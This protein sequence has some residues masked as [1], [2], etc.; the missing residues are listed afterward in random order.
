MTKITFRDALAS[1]HRALGQPASGAVA[2]RHRTLVRLAIGALALG[3]SLALWPAAA[4]AG[5]LHPSFPLLDE[6]GVSVL[7]S[8]NAVSPARTC[9]TCHDTNYI[10]SQDSHATS[11]AALD[12][13]LC[14]LAGADDDARKDAIASGNQRWAATAT[15]SSTGIV[16]A[17]DGT[18]AYSPEAFDAQGNVRRSFLSVQ[19]PTSDACGSCH[20]TVE[21]DLETP[22]LWP[23]VDPVTAPKWSS[24]QTGQVFSPQPMN[25]SGLN[26][27]EKG[28]LTRTWDVHAERRLDCVDCHYST[29]NP[30]YRRVSSVRPDHLRFDARRI[31]LGEYLR[32]PSHILAH[33]VEVEAGD[34]EGT[35]RDCG[36]C[37]DSSVGHDWLP[38]AERHFTHL[39][40][41]ACH[42]PD[43]HAPALAA[44]DAT[45]ARA[46]GAPRIHLRG[47]EGPAADQWGYDLSASI[48]STYVSG[49]QPTLL[50]RVEADGTTRLAPHNLVTTYRWIDTNGAEV[51][52]TTVAAALYDGAGRPKPSI[53]ALFDADGNGTWSDTELRISTDAQK[54]GVANALAATGVAG[55]KLD[56]LTVPYSITHGVT[57]GR[58]A[59]RDCKQ[60]HEE[61]SR[62][63][64]AVVL[65]TSGL[66]GIDP[67]FGGDART[68]LAGTIRNDADGQ[69]RFSPEPRPET[70]VLGKHA[71]VVVNRIGLLSVLGVILGIG[72]HALARVIK[73]RMSSTNG[74]AAHGHESHGGHAGSAGGAAKSVYMYSAYERFWHWLQAAAI[75]FLLVTGLEIH[76]PG[77][78]RILGFELAVR[79][80]NIIAFVVVLNAALAAFFHFA[81][82]EIRQFLPEPQGFFR[83]AILQI[84]YYLF[85]I[86]RGEPHPFEK[87]PNQ[88]MNALQQVTYLAILN[89]LLPLQI[90]TGL[91][92]WGAQ[93][94]STVDSVFG[95]LGVLGPIH[96]LGAWLFAAFLV[97]HMYLTTTGPTPTA[98]VKAMVTGWE[99]EPATH[100]ATEN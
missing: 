32:R 88:K 47:V 26:L 38:Y 46:D 90:G 21:L 77:T 18:Y 33:G 61:N 53:L 14:H 98:Y 41:A 71:N 59:L 63:D 66:P 64:R 31:E 36:T 39:S 19:D 68:S 11:G 50:P 94:W 81:S 24:L 7:E 97:V 51:P 16:R 42:V 37:H 28:R 60:C 93:R 43:M 8:A 75:F 83:G 49:Y 100:L 74:T 10:A 22:F 95:G 20:G 62:I 84:R 89:L 9:G 86:F 12:C 15:L 54:S 79:S 69:V 1:G 57:T 44:V 35:M 67:T 91:L 52:G 29:N 3:V 80:H 96:A 27:R 2:L 65:A 48:A 17:E 87:N 78:F 73:T 23:E 58:W 5:E 45:V 40:C 56:A 6:S 34:T 30:I 72:V 25:E 92:I 13:F 99:E 70:Y 76:F 4:T 82:G 55:P 85:G